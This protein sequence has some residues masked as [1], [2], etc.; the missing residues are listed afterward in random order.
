MAIDILDTL[1]SA[2]GSPV[3]RQVSTLFGDSEESTRSGLRSSFSALLAGVLHK[4]TTPGGAEDVYR[5]VTSDSVDASLPSRVTSLL[6]NRGSLDSSIGAGESMLSSIFGNRTSGVAHAISEVSGLKPSSATGL[7]AMAAPMLMGVLKKHVTQN[8]LDARGL[9]SVLLGQRN[10]L[11]SAGLDSRI[12]SAMGLSSLQSVF[13]TGGPSAT[14]TEP[15]RVQSAA[16]T[17]YTRAE[18]HAAAEIY[19]QPTRERRRSWI[20]WAVAAA[21]AIAILGT[22]STRFGRHARTAPVASAARTAPQPSMLPAAVYF[23]TDRADLTPNSQHT[24]QAVASSVR[25]SSAPVAVTGYTDPSGDPNHN[26][27][28][29]KNRASAVRD[30]LVREGVA[31]SRVVMA[32]PSTITPGASADESRRVEIKLAEATDTGAGAVR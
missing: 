17:G 1:K 22:L 30:A 6:G 2:F 14:Y 9:G 5:A 20:P 24:I 19:S 3:T 18:H 7:L 15:P 26:A 13:G 29:A 28:L 31:P 4:S 12:T 21:L 23:D 10:A 32:P 25:A 11:Q 27:E 8:N 16:N